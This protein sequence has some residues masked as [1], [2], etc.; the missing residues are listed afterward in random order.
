MKL[1]TSGTIQRWFAKADKGTIVRRPNL[2]RFAHDNNIRYMIVRGKWLI[3]GED[4]MRKVNPR[5]ITETAP[6]PILR[7]LRDC[8]NMII[9]KHGVDI[10]KHDIERAIASGKVS[11]Y[12]YGQ[13]KWILNYDEV[14]KEVLWELEHCPRKKV[15]KKDLD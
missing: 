11:A 13:K 8:L 15:K 3:D 6:M 9:E 7:C 10:D 14:E 1:V 5:G 4:F 12:H 2:R